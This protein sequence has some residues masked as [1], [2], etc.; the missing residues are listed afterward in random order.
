MG[1]SIVDPRS[2]GG[3]RADLRDVLLGGSPGDTHFRVGYMG[4]NPPY[5]EDPVGFPLPGGM[6]D[7]GETPPTMSRWE[8]SLPSAGG[9]DDKGGAERTGYLHFH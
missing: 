7:H 2:G 6:M 5:G 8:L 1:P 4:G 9:R 3:G